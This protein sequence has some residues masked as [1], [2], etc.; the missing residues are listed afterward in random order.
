MAFEVPLYRP[1]YVGK[2]TPQKMSLPFSKSDTTLRGE[3][4]SEREDL[5][6][7]AAALSRMDERNHRLL[8]ATAQRMVQRKAAREA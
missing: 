4:G 5:G 7:F 6:K 1:F 3:S 2:E 8:L